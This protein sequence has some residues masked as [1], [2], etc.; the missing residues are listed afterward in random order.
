MLSQSPPRKRRSR[1]ARSSD[2]GSWGSAGAAG[3]VA[4]NAANA[5][6]T[7]PTA[8]KV[9][10]MLTASATAPNI[11]PTIAPKTAAPKAIPISSP[12][13]DRGAATVS[14]ASA[15][16]QVVVLEKP[17]TN[18]ARP[19]AHG[20]EASAKP[21]LASASSVRPSDDRSLGAESHR[22]DSAGDAAEE[23]ARPERADEQSRAGLRE[24]ELV[25]IAGHERRERAEEHRVDEDDRADE[26]EQPAHRPTLPTGAGLRSET[27]WPSEGRGACV[28]RTQARP[29]CRARRA[30]AL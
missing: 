1:S 13:R 23:S 7:T 6:A 27:A 18:R 21:K 5:S 11:G 3:R 24:L 12:R 20:P 26:D 17:W 4:A 14:H 15:P 10:R 28:E 25:G 9:A 8:P 19:S 22:G 2:A 30:N 29:S 16:A